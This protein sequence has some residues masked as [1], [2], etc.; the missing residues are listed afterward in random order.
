M[1]DTTQDFFFS[2]ASWIRYH[3]VIHFEDYPVYLDKERQS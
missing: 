1:L 2:N 3:P